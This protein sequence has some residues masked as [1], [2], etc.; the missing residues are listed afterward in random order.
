M[1]LIFKRTYKTGYQVR[2]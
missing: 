1:T 2:S